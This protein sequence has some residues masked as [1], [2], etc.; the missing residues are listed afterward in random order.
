LLVSPKLPH[1]ST[2]QLI[3]KAAGLLSEILPFYAFLLQVII[4]L[5]MLGRKSIEVAHAVRHRGC[6]NSEAQ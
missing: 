1:L 2:E 5:L 4:Q 6:G 3:P